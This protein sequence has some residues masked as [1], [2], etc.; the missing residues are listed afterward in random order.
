M[1]IELGPDDVAFRCNIVTIEQDSMKDFAAGHIDSAFTKIVI[2]EIASAI[3]KPG[4]EFYAGVSY[5]NIMVVR[6]FKGESPLTTPPHDIQGKA[7][8]EYLPK[9]AH[10]DLL[11]EIM[12]KAAVAIAHSKK[13]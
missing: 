5:R 11:N 7:T 6:N 3:T 12:Q 13:P 8:Y 4:I 10:S 1:G 2:D 9:G